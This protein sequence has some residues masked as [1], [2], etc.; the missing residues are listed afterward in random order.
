MTATTIQPSASTK[1]MSSSSCSY[2]TMSQ[3]DTTY[4]KEIQA[5]G[6]SDGTLRGCHIPL[7]TT[8]LCPTQIR[9]A[10][11]RKVNCRL[12]QTGSTLFRK[13]NLRAPLNSA[14]DKSLAARIVSSICQMISA[15]RLSVR[16]SIWARDLLLFFIGT[17]GGLE[18]ATKSCPMWV[19]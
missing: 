5:H 16:R 13:S 10:R 9:M 4:H 18:R 1:A 11:Y 3:L 7:S 12:W 6:A 15:F 19:M 17:L 14:Y 8:P 2:L